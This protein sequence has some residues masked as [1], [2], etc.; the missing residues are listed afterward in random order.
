MKKRKNVGAVQKRANTGVKAVRYEQ[1][2]QP[3]SRAAFWVRLTA[4]IVTAAVIFGVMF[5]FLEI[6]PKYRQ[7]ERMREMRETIVESAGN[8]G[9]AT[10][11]STAAAPEVLTVSPAPNEAADETLP[12]QRQTESTEEN[13]SAGQEEASVPEETEA[14]A[15]FSLK[16]KFAE[17][18]SA[19]TVKEKYDYRSRGV[20]VQIT[21]LTDTE[22][23]SKSFNAY[24]ADIHVASI[25]ALQSGFP[26]SGRTATTDRIV[27]D[28]DAIIGVNGDYYLNIYKGLIVRNGVA[29]QT[30]EGTA[31]ICV[32]YR[33]GTMKTYLPGEYS[34]EGILNQEPW[35][36]WSFGPALL[37]EEG[38]AK[39]EF[40]TSANIAS[41]NPRTAIGYYE[42]GHYC[43]V[44]IDGRLM[45]NSN[46]ASMRAL[47]AF[48]ADLGCVAAYN[49]DGGAS[50][51]MVFS[52][53]TISKPSGG[54]RAVSDIVMLCELPEPPEE[55]DV[56]ETATEMQT[57]AEV[58]PENEAAASPADGLDKSLENSEKGIVA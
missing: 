35:Q 36:V 50:S 8:A 37:D 39:T 38:M 11:A 46:G 32:I 3:H 16:E 51:S 19:E 13:A 48:M 27:K 22:H 18:F 49:L 17:Y 25:E 1:P 31:D 54:G 33:D 12:V 30:E 28:N 45:G 24:I 43:L 21:K 52:G 53:K 10:P 20:S 9:T 56:D 6:L 26:G 41:R 40:N 47:S 57:E 4:D 44:V 55:P 5:L 34:A 29:L 14:A 23:G 42:P 58:A 7:F 2:E 15:E